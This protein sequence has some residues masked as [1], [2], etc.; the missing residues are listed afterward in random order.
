MQNGDE[1]HIQRR[2]RERYG[3][4]LTTEEMKKLEERVRQRDGILSRKHSEKQPG[5]VWLVQVEG[6]TV[7]L[8]YDR[9]G[10][11]RLVTALPL[12]VFEKYQDGRV[13]TSKEMKK[14]RM[15]KARRERRRNRASEELDHL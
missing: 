12:S 9:V 3:L 15:R 4:L 8:V 10:T 2:L 6:Q 11:S 13:P 5:E 7:R 14:K 1:I